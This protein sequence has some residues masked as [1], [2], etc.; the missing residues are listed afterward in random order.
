MAIPDKTVSLRDVLDILRRRRAAMLL[1]FVGV[2]VIAM[3]AAFLWP[4]TYQAAGTILIEQQEVP[5]E[6]VRSTISSY[7]DQ[8]IQVITQQ[9]MTTENLYKIVQKYDLYQRERRLKTREAVMLKMR[10]DIGFKMISADVIDPRSGNPTKA[11]IAFA[12]SYKNRSPDM[13]ARVAN[14]LVSLYL[15]QNLQSRKERS[16]DATS[17]LGD[18]AQRLDQ[19][20]N[21]LQAEVAKF[22]EKHVNDL[23]EQSPINMQL[24]TRADEEMRDV[25]TRIRSLDQQVVYLEAQLAQLSPSSQVY[26]STG[27][28]VLSPQDRLKYLRTEYA[29]VSGL[30]APTHPDVIRLQREIAGLEKTADASGAVNDL[31]RQVEDANTQLAAVQQKYSAD[32]PDVIRQQRVVASL[33]TKL[34]A[35]AKSDNSAS[36]RPVEP[37]NPAYIQI[38]AQVEASKSERSSLQTKRSQLTAQLAD[39]EKRL[40][41]APAVE[42]EYSTM[43]RDL[44]NNQ[45]KY[46]EVRQKQMEAQVAQS[47]EEERKGERFT[48]IEPPLTP[49][50]PASPNRVVI[51]VLGLV[52]SIGAAVGAAALLENMDSSV[53]NRRDLETLL[54]VPPLAVLPWIET[55]ADRVARRRRQRYTWAGAIGGVVVA[56]SAV[57]VFYRPLDVLWQVAL[58]RLAG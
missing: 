33:Q 25:D 27:E 45:L 4:A 51:M 50:E 37:D 54:S 8:R 11:T 30:Y 26:T 22:K 2:I 14:E 31:Q 58:R 39:Y 41:S 1:A 10:D 17:F 48:L 20:I 21:E 16:A 57:H 46:R 5:A 6:L 7:A 36:V 56:I 23:P 18:E 44:D 35:A 24:M 47:L 49:E 9:V 40:A 52:L 12:V 3:L 42:R 28:R 15:Q 53:R 32:H 13:A 29:R 38:K 34:A 55:Q 19:R 43:T